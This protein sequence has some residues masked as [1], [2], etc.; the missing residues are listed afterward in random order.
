[1]SVF[2]IVKHYHQFLNPKKCCYKRSATTTS[3]L[4]KESSCTGRKRIE[5]TVQTPDTAF[6]KCRKNSL[7]PCKVTIIGSRPWLCPKPQFTSCFITSLLVP[8]SV[9]APTSIIPICL[10]KSETI[11]IGESPGKEMMNP[12]T[13]TSLGVFNIERAATDNGKSKSY[14]GGNRL[15]RKVLELGLQALS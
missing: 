1:M 7:L 3:I 6:S 12:T 4:E 14:A 15:S 2:R 11:S 10:Q 13:A 5:D 9:S 8:T